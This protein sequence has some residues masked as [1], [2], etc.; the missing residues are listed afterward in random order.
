MQ[1]AAIALIKAEQQLVE[2]VFSGEEPR[3]SEGVLG[4]ICRACVNALCSRASEICHHG[5]RFEHPHQQLQLGAGARESDGGGGGGSGSVSSVR[6]AM[7]ADQLFVSLDLY[8]TTQ[9]QLPRFRSALHGCDRS[10]RE[11]CEA[12]LEATIGDFLARSTECLSVF[13]RQLREVQVWDRARAEGGIV[14]EL[15]TTALSFVR[16]CT[17]YRATL[18]TEPDLV[19]CLE[20]IAGDSLY[21]A[22]GTSMMSG[23]PD[24]AGAGGGSVVSADGRRQSFGA[25]TRGRLLPRSPPRRGSVGGAPGQQAQQPGGAEAGGAQV[26]LAPVL[27][28]ILDMVQT[29]I[30]GHAPAYSG[31]APLFILNNTS[32][33][34]ARLGEQPQRALRQ[35]S[36]LPATH[37]CRPPCSPPTSA[38]GS[39]IRDCSCSHDWLFRLLCR[40]SVCGSDHERV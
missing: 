7:V 34:L 36:R 38:I 13:T 30:Q 9:R 26:Q 39:S 5:G 40:R 28:A 18:T 27:R 31:L 19:E 32:Y 11:T 29:R 16:R 15:T 24:T 35:V 12:L 10:S 6:P 1:G 8:E 37:S 20:A 23:G 4:S 3:D 2:R 17:D 33:L 21:E 22:A 14:H 25:G